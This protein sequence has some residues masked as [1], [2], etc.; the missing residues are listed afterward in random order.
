MD[1]EEILKK[2]KEI[3]EEEKKKNAQNFDKELLELCKKYNIQL[4][5]QILIQSL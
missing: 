1:N 3:I 5:P 2:A 4:V